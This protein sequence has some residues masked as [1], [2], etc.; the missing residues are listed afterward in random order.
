[1]ANII[2]AHFK[3]IVSQ[4][5]GWESAAAAARGER[6]AVAELS[7]RGGVGCV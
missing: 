3:P 5:V 6:T 7:S 1:M 2:T 4:Q